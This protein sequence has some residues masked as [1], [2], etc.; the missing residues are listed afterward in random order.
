MGENQE[1][2]IQITGSDEIAKEGNTT[3]SSQTIINQTKMTHKA[4][5]M[6]WLKIFVYIIFILLGQAVATLLG[7]LYFDKGG[8]SK[9]LGTL[10]QVA[11]FPIFF[12]Y[13]II[14]A[15]KQKT[16]TNN[17][18]QTEQQPTLLKLVMVYLTLGLLLAADCYL[19]SIGLMYLPV[20]TYSLISSSQ[21]A[22]NAI[23]SFFLNSQKFTPPIINSLVLLTISS[24][25][26]VFQTESDGS[27][28]NKTSKAKYIL[29]FLCTIAGSAGYGLV[30]SL[31]QLFFNKVIKSESFK[32]I[33][34]LIVYR[35]FVACLAIV[36]GLFVSG[37]WRGLK[38]E[39]Y[40]FEL[41]KVSYFMTLIW[42]AIVWKAY[43]IGCVGLIAEVSSLFSNAVC[44][45][46]SPLVPVAAVII[47]HDKMS[48]LKGVAMALAVWGFISYAYQQYLDDCNKSKENSKSS[49]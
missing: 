9:W 45:L 18:S 43:A 1:K 41:G 31:T 30:L 47:F 21:L 25:L 46:G 19:L 11:G 42:T 8:K 28:Y 34:D 13:Y 10:V 36:V 33:V 48:G 39:M 44:V 29:G 24:T 16:S 5:Y 22:F 20:S 14:I 23:F 17:I 37:E 26:L 32:V 2:C 15:T 12:P 27:A 49:L 4:N 40:E 6:K 7:R 3:E 35:S 38:K